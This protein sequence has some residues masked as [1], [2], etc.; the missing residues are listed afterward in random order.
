MP[1]YKTGMGLRTILSSHRATRLALGL[2]L[3]IAGCS[4]AEPPHSDYF[5]VF[6]PA[7]SA[8]PL[9][10]G[11]AALARAGEDAHRGSPHAVLVTGYL[12]ADGNDRELSQQRMQEVAQ[13]LAHDGVPAGTIHVAP[14]TVPQAT[15]ARLGN[16]VIVQIERG[17][18]PQ[19]EKPAPQGD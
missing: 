7:G 9:P 14:E 5:V 4:S 15:F 1:G 11:R 16:G 10:E 17:T 8:V 6:F 13:M 2:A 19:A 18:V 12:S 3:L